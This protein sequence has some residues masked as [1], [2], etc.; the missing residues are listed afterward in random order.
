MQG[1][2]IQFP[3]NQA[4]ISPASNRLLDALTGVAL[5][6][7]DFQVEIG[8]HT[9]NKGSDEYNLTLSQLRADSVREYLIQRGVEA[10]SVKAVGYGESQPIDPRETVE[11]F[12]RNRRT[13]FKVTPRR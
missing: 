5:I 9:D 12:A 7:R 2:T 11:A 10:S 8:G 4:M 3:S 13:E 1:R 6:C